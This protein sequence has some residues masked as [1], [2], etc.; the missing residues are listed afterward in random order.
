MV[1]F[2]I[3]YKSFNFCI[4]DEEYKLKFLVWKEEKW[5]AAIIIKTTI[6]P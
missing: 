6:H 2:F 5:S 4:C 3:A 1:A